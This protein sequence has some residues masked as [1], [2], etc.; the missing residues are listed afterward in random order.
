MGLGNERLC[1]DDMDDIDVSLNFNMSKFPCKG[2][3]GHWSVSSRHFAALEM[4]Q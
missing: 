3:T 2:E 1:V 4:A